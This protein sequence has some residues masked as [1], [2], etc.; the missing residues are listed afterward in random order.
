MTTLRTQLVAAC[1]CASLRLSA[2]TNILVGGDLETPGP[3]GQ[4]DRPNELWHRVGEGYL[5]SWPDW[6][7]TTDTAVSGKRAIT[8]IGSR[9]FVAC[10]E[11]AE[12]EFRGV[13]T[14]RA[15]QP[16]T[17]VRLRLS[18]W[19]RLSRTDEVRDVV[20][21]PAWQRFDVVTRALQ[22]GPVEL[23]VT[24]LTPGA[25]VWA[26]DLQV[27]A[28]PLADQY[29][30]L[31]GEGDAQTRR[32]VDVVRPARIDL[33]AL[34]AHAGASADTTG[35]VPIIL[36]LPEACVEVGGVSGGVPL[37]RGRLF[38]PEHVAVL[39][40]NRQQAPAQVTVL[41]R[42]LADGSVRMLLVAL[43]MQATTE[44]LALEFGPQV[45]RDPVPDPLTVRRDDGGVVVRTGAVEA[46]FAAGAP[47]PEAGDRQFQGPLVTLPDAGLCEPHD[48]QV[49]PELVGPLT[50]TVK[51]EGRLRSADGRGAGR[52]VTRYEFWRG[53]ARVLVRHT[54]INDEPP[55]S[56]VPVRAA[57]FGVR[58][59]L[60]E[61]GG[62]SPRW[63]TQV[64]QANRGLVSVATA[65]PTA[66]GER[67][68]TRH[69][70]RFD[71]LAVRDFS[72]NHPIAVQQ[73]P[74]AVRLWLWPPTVKGVILPQ[75]FAR[76]WEFLVDTRGV[77]FER[78]FR[79]R[80]LPILRTA[81]EWACASGVFEFVLPPDPER[82]PIFEARVGSIPTLGNSSVA[83]KE[84][85]G[86]YGVFNYGDAPGDGGWA[87]LESMTDHEL[88]LHW[89][90]TGSREHF[91]M[92]RLA[93][94]HYR[95]VDIHHGAGFCHTHC[96]NHVYAE[97]GWSHAWIQGVR[98]LFLLTGDLR[99][100]EVLG[101]VGERLLTKPVGW[102]TGRDWTRAIDN[103]VD[104][105]AATG[106]RRY[107]D[108]VRQHVAELG[109]R[110]L[111]E[112]AICGAERGSWYEDR[113]PAGCAFTWYGCQA[114]AKLHHE[115]ADPAVAGILRRE[116]DC[117]LDV[118][119]KC[120]RSHDD[121]PG[122]TV[123]A[124]R[125]AMILA[126]PFALGRGS[127][128]F[129]PLGYLGAI[130]A[131][132]RYLDLG[133]NI[134]A[135]YM[136]NLR[137][138]TDA[139]ATAYATVFLHYARQAGAGPD[140]EAAAFQ[141]ARDVSFESWPDQVLNDDFE[142]TG[143]AGW[144]VKKIPG[145]DF[146]YDQLVHVGYYLDD[147][148]RHSGRRSLRLHSDNPERVMS[149]T[150][151]FRLAPKTRWRL[152]L[153]RRADAAMRPDASLSLREY[154][155]DR[156]LGVRLAPEGPPVDGWQRFQ[157][158]F[159]SVARTVATLTL[160]NR[161]GTGDAW[162]DDVAVE[163]LG[164]AHN[165]LTG[166]GGGRDWRQPAA[167]G[168][169]QD[170]GGSYRPDQPM[171]GDAEAG[172]RPIRF[173]E[174]SLTDGEASYDHLQKPLPSYAYWTKR[175]RGTLTFDL[176]RPCRVHTVRVN[177]LI[178]PGTHGTQR[179][180]LR[181][182][183]ADGALLAAAEPAVDGWN[184]FADLDRLTQHLTLILTALPGAP[185]L[186]LSEVEVW[187]DPAPA[188]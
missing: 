78:P 41:S 163:A 146:F 52:F 130:T 14:V 18:W 160:T 133:M 110:Q 16:D 89:L 63:L 48:C 85:T 75:G 60:A 187:G 57:A 109:R 119:T 134:L 38:H 88:F 87:N 34:Q 156:R 53:S 147:T 170:L 67:P 138:G 106:D 159:L 61:A 86:L 28:T 105:A 117:S 167:P 74:E 9:E 72:E 184:T 151:T 30:E 122:T 144:T 129:P 120:V 82:F 24:S 116:M 19:R 114:M 83:A 6:R 175:P 32:R 154:D 145:Q 141:R 150:T 2:Q 132:K 47:G 46:R 22:G 65:V 95:D 37:P 59:P 27:L 96:N 76:Q 43:P 101:E 171:R 10:G 1:L 131:E 169:N 172:D 84:R 64:M 135:H 179:L 35:Q 71:W 161:G 182:D 113:Y 118:A 158:D 112:K 162:F 33:E 180:E 50:A 155:V 80:C 20:A 137:G 23:G 31:L 92:A 149:V 26:D 68:E 94:E 186:T 164:P 3:A 139:S 91:D 142:G 108:S 11:A 73:G 69:D 181:A 7:L 93:A 103:L 115:T 183:S 123:S 21:G 165:L 45:Q 111:P 98:D 148:A 51:V 185:Y 121:L 15:A 188:P 125:Q 62:G 4:E 157:G 90:R 177:I 140:Q 81:P 166:N 124:D 70:G 97:E 176:G 136:L 79:T 153:W 42:W 178:R 152:S 44:G 143:F 55:P 168:L 128:L 56:G 25:R 17:R 8:T 12:G 40:R 54:W 173:A 102:T 99:A 174:G 100:F 58:P 126:D 77:P 5:T 36:D 29:I 107:L 13:V 66:G 39:D 104:I 127:T 49:R